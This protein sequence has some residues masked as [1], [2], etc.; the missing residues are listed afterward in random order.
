MQGLLDHC[1]DEKQQQFEVNKEDQEK[2][3]LFSLKSAVS[4]DFLG[5]FCENKR[6]LRFMKYRNNSKQEK[7]KNIVYY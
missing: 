4:D 2:E 5:L 1:Q 7:L 3:T 6:L